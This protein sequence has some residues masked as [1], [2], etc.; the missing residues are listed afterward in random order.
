MNP[1]GGVGN[2]QLGMEG[3][4]YDFNGCR[5][6]STEY[7]NTHRVNRRTQEPES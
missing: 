5:V 4:E 1:V 2:N 3:W 7:L 6:L